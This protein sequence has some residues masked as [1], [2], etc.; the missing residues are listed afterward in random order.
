MPLI[1]TRL[2]PLVRMRGIPFRRHCQI[3]CLSPSQPYAFLKYKLY[4]IKLNFNLYKYNLYFIKHKLYFKNSVC[5]I[6]FQPTSAPRS[7]PKCFS[8]G[9]FV[10]YT[11]FIYIRYWRSYSSD[12]THNHHHPPFPTTKSLFSC[13]KTTIFHILTQI[14]WRGGVDRDFLLTFA[15]EYAKSP[16][17]GDTKDILNT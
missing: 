8:L 17:C 4:F 13:S 10:G 5:E 14:N 6:P 12:A 16:H 9:S 11:L 15:L 7:L 3:V 2:Q 1:P